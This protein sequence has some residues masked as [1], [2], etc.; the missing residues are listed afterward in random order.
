MRKEKQNANNLGESV[1]VKSGEW[2]RLEGWVGARLINV[3][4]VIPG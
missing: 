3:L 2:E 1:V 4:M